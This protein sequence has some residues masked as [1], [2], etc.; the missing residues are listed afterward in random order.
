MKCLICVSYADL[1]ILLSLHMPYEVGTLLLTSK[2]QGGDI[3][4]VVSG[5]SGI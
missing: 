1:N 4:V 3:T 2:A 5:E